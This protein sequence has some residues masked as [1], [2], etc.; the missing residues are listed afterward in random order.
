MRGEHPQTVAIILAHLEPP[1][2]ASV[3]KELDPTFGAEV[4]LTYRAR[5][6]EGP[7][8]TCS[9]FIEALDPH[10]DRSR[11]GA[12]PHDVGRSG[13]SVAEVLN[14]DIAPSLEKA[15]MRGVEDKDPALCEQIRNLMFVFEDVVSLDDRSLQRVCFAT[16][17]RQGARARSQGG[18]S[19]E[20]RNKLMGAMSAAR[21]PAA[22]KEQMEVIGPARKSGTSRRRRSPSSR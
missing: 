19:N 18:R 13:E 20:V 6:E 9:C 21:A 17:R 15:I 22:L 16:D 4:V 12:E 7:R 3:L 10:G 14:L 2:P 5:M 11:T 1:H 8:P